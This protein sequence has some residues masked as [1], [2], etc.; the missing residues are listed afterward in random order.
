[1][2]LTKIIGAFAGAVLGATIAGLFL[3]AALEHSSAPAIAVIGFVLFGAFL[4]AAIGAYIGSHD[5]K[6]GDVE[7]VPTG[8]DVESRLRRLEALRTRGLL[9]EGEYEQRRSATLEAL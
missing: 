8:D 6:H 3:G 1:M 7:Y 2:S 5:R 4:G 9:T